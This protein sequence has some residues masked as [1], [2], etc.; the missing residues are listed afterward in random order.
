MPITV[1]CF[2]SPVPLVELTARVT[3][4]SIVFPTRFSCC[5]GTSI[6]PGSGKAAGLLWTSFIR[7][8]NGLRGVNHHGP[9]PSSESAMSAGG[10]IPE[11]P[12]GNTCSTPSSFP[13]C[14]TA[15]VFNGGL[16][17]PL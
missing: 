7:S 2:A 17:G 4:T 16:F 11:M 13:S 10:S 5:P 1:K 6:W 14:L 8:S 9:A 15:F 3:L 12:D